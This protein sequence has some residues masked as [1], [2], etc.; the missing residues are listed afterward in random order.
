MAYTHARSRN[1]S[2]TRAPTILPDIAEL[3]PNLEPTRAPPVPAT[4]RKPQPQPQPQPRTR[5]PSPT[6]RSVSVASF[7]SDGTIEIDGFG[8]DSIGDDDDDGDEDDDGLD[9]DIDALSLYGAESVYEDSVFGDYDADEG[10]GGGNGGARES[11]DLSRRAERIL[12]SAKRRL[13]RCGQNISRARNSIILSP[14]L[15]PTIPVLGKETPTNEMASIASVLEM[16]DVLGQF[17]VP[18]GEKWRRMEQ[19]PVGGFGGL[20]EHMRTASE[21]AVVRSESAGA[22]TLQGMREENDNGSAARS[23]SAQQMRSLRDQMKDLRGKISSLQEQAQRDRERDNVRR[24]TSV[25]SLRSNH[26]SNGFYSTPSLEEI[27]ESRVLDINTTNEWDDMIPS[28]HHHHHHHR[29]SF[30]HRFSQ[31]SRSSSRSSG[32]P[33]PRDDLVTSPF[34]ERHEDRYDA[35]SYDAL[36]IGTSFVHHRR[37]LSSSSSTSTA[38][39]QQQHLERASSQNSISSYATATESLSPRFAA[40]SRS[41]SA[42]TIRD[43]PSPATTTSSGVSS[44]GTAILGTHPL[45]PPPVKSASSSS[46]SSSLSSRSRGLDDQHSSYHSAPQTPHLMKPTPSPSS[47]SSSASSSFSSRTPKTKTKP[48]KN[49]QSWYRDSISTETEAETETENETVDGYYTD[50]SS[51]NNLSSS[52]SSHSHPLSYP[53]HDRQQRHQQR[54]R[55]STTSTSSSRYST[56]TITAF[57]P[58]TPRAPQPPRHHPHHQPVSIHA[59][60]RDSQTMIV[61]GVIEGREEVELKVGREDRVLIEGV[62]ETLGRVCCELE[63]VG[64]GKGAEGARD[65]GGDTGRGGDMGINGRGMEMEERREVLRERLRGAMRVLEGW[66]GEVEMF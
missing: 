23:R 39:I 35:F 22:R 11:Q 50:Q 16:E 52:S 25:S 48:M 17:P 58:P 42:D 51:D 19:T 32:T 64:R 41:N 12:A 54:Q 56:D 66:E 29:D 63:A 49:E 5:I 65:N 18:A 55:M 28:H 24:R 57:S 1:L 37:T 36:L 33:K 13:D 59:S 10:G 21:S 61:N 34:S 62:I 15:S 40:I 44:P 14:S 38:T 27:R 4:A 43:N 20:R 53:P 47:S 60:H 3:S 8:F 30:H 31:A 45:R 9:R 6:L 7:M 46:S 2:T 26:S